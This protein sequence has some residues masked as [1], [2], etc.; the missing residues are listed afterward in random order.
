MTTPAA[1][2]PPGASDKLDAGL[3]KIAGVTVLGAI[4]SILDTTV[5]SV[6]LPT[7]QTVFD[8]TYSTVAWTMTGYTLA[9]ATVIPLTGWAADRF[10]TKR[11]YMLALV[12]FILGSVACGLAWNIGSL[13]TFRVLQ[14]LGGG[15]LMPLGMTMMTRAAGPARIGR[16][17]AVLGVPMLLGP[18][19]GPILGGWL[20][21]V[22]SWHW[23][24]FINL[25]I[26]IIAFIAAWRVL[27]KDSPTPSE[28]FD[29]LGMLL[30]SPGLALF[31]YGVSSIPGEGTIASAQVIIPAVIGVLLMCAFVWHALR[32]DHPLIDLHLFKRKQLSVSIITMS[33]FAIAFFGAMLLFPTYFISVRGE[34]TLA[35]GLLL[36]PQ[37]IGAMVTM[38]IAGRL[39]D[40]MGPGKFVLGG[41][42]L[43][44]AGMGVF[45]QLTDTTSYVLIL[46]SLFVMGMGMGMT[47]MPV[48]TAA[49]ASLNHQEV[50]RGSTLM[51]I[52]QQAAASVGTATMSV[53]LTNQLL[54]K[55][56]YEAGKA[57]QA[58]PS[59]AANFPPQLL[60]EIP[61]QMA[62]AFAFTFWV[63]LVLI[64]LT[65]IPAFLLPRKARVPVDGDQVVAQV[66]MH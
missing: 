52:V 29:F 63:A 48:M 19:G 53:I 31:L 24:F 40:K 30:L 14:G 20:I 37:G 16:V 7:F 4:M 42:V 6:A 59:Q 9:L 54:N 57:I 18:I 58:D 62:E 10:G 3:M 23:I 15:M 11:L 66:T 38:P 50:A 65:L 5:V 46:G 32:K 39:T 27:A 35:A 2:A 8:A 28:K 17:M 55:P 51:N 64:V 36:A 60:A 44:A 49:L 25:P 13:I 21:E 12:L 56:A 43:I 41:L 34:T 22:A 26:G 47:M 33:L 1:Q 45:T 61:A